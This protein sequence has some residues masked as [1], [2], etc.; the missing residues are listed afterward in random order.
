MARH[1]QFLRFIGWSAVYKVTDE[2]DWVQM[3]GEN[4]VRCDN[5]ALKTGKGL[6]RVFEAFSGGETSWMGVWNRMWCSC[7]TDPYSTLWLPDHCVVVY[8]DERDVS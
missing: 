8:H 1:K 5:A 4:M 6:W 7:K 3:V 2:T